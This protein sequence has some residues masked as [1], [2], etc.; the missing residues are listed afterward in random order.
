MKYEESPKHHPNVTGYVSKAPTD[1]QTALNN[2]VRIKDTSTR[3]LGVDK[4][5]NELV[6]FDETHPGKEIYHGHIRTWEQLT[7]EMKNVLQHAG[8]LDKRGKI[9]L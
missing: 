7:P 6:V 3:R 9:I 8:F 1:G 2:S 4:I 5:N